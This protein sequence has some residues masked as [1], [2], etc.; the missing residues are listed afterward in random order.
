MASAAQNLKE[1][2]MQWGQINLQ[3][4]AKSKGG[5]LPLLRTQQ[6]KEYMKPSLV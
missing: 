4:I 1:K 5:N 3:Y 2:Y 6:L